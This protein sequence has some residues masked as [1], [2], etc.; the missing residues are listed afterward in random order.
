MIYRFSQAEYK[1]RLSMAVPDVVY[2]GEK[3]SKNMLAAFPRPIDFKHMTRTEREWLEKAG[4][5]EVRRFFTAVDLGMLVAKSQ[6]EIKGQAYSSR[7]LG[8]LMIDQFAGAECENVCVACTDVHNDIIEFTT[9]FK[10]GRSECMIYPDQIYKLALQCS[11][12]G[13]A[14]IHNHPSGKIAPSQQDLAFAKRLEQ[15]CILLGIQLL[16]FMVIGHEDYY[17]WR[18]QQK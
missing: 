18:E 11:A 7:E 8:R 16:D 17:S 3:L 1:K 14:L 13:L 9:L 10:G 6:P 12:S 4:G 15:G 5:D 2:K